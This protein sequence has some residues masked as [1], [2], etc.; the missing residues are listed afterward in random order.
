MLLI[1]IN[2][3][4]RRA[5]TPCPHL[6]AIDAG[7]W[8]VKEHLLVRAQIP[9]DPVSRILA[10]LSLTTAT[11]RPLR[12]KMRASPGAIK[13]GVLRGIFSSNEQ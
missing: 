1:V 4:G 9:I 6:I 3:C 8:R 2:S 7:G 13:D 11:C 10:L 5:G 12:L